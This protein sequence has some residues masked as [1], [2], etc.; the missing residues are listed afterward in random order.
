MKKL[1]RRLDD[2]TKY[3]VATILLAVPLYP[4]FPPSANICPYVSIRLEDFLLVIAVLV[5]AAH[6]LPNLSGFLKDKINRA[7][8][9]FLLVGL[10]SLASAVFITKT[11]QPHLGIMHWIRRV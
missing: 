9:I 5:L 7:I 1:L 2:I 8:F 3:L 11:A 6:I 4:Q 10:I